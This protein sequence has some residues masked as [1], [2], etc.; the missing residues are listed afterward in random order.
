[1][2]WERATEALREVLALQLSVKLVGSAGEMVGEVR[3]SAVAS[4]VEALAQQVQAVQ[5]GV[6]RAEAAQQQPPRHWLEAQSKALEQASPGENV[7]QVP[8]PGWQ[9]VQPRRAAAALQ[10]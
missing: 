9:A 8:E 5:L 4:V 10:Q 7:T 2:T 6:C 3:V 1:M